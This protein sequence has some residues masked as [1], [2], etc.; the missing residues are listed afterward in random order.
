MRQV[1][2]LGNLYP[3]SIAIFTYHVWI[4]W[5]Q[6]LGRANLTQLPGVVIVAKRRHKLRNW[7]IIAHSMQ[8][9]I[10]NA[11]RHSLQRHPLQLRLG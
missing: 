6:G 1:L 10:V 2:V 9:P 7:I 5:K 3:I 11:M 8:R 4:V